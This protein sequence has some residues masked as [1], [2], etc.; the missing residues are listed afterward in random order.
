[1]NT[2]EK[3]FLFGFLRLIVLGLAAIIN[4]SETD[5]NKFNKYAEIMDSEYKRWSSSRELEILK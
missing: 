2:K 1:M 4:L 5:T 3:L